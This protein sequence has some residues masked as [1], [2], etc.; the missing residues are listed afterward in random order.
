MRAASLGLDGGNGYSVKVT[1]AFSCTFQ[2]SNT[3]K[4][5]EVCGEEAGAMRN[6]D[7][8]TP[9]TTVYWSVEMWPE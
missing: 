9:R 5:K 8:L 4:Y 1:V 7:N 2:Y 6:N 3:F